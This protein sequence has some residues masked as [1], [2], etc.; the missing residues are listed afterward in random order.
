M[1]VSK[2][3]TAALAASFITSASIAQ[4]VT[5]EV[6]Y[7]YSSL[8]DVTFKR[9]LPLFNAA[10]PDITVK[11][12]ATYDNYEDATNT[13]LRES[14]ADKL[15]DVSFQGLNRQAGLVDKGIAK[16]LDPYIAKEANFSKEGYHQAMLDLG[17]FKG[18][19]YGLPF[20]VSL[21]VGFYN[22]DLLGKAGITTLPTTWDE[23]IRDCGKLRES[24][25][26]NPLFWGWNITG[27]W[28]FQALMWSQGEPI[29]K[30]GKVNFDGQAGLNALNTMKKLFRECKMLNL[31]V[32]DAGRP[33]VAGEV[34]MHFW[35]TSA[36]GA[37]ERAKGDFVLKTNEYPGMG[38][39]PKGL[40]A[41]G[42]SA[43]LVSGS[44]DPA[45]LDAAWQ[46][47]KFATSGKG[48]A[49]VAETTGYMP[50]NKAA[51]EMLGDFYSANPNKHTAVRQAG[52]LRE[53]I[54]YPGNNSLAIT[55]VI[56]DA[57][58]S[59]VTGESDD[60]EALQEELV[61]EVNSML[62]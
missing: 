54:A 11:F 59:I 47:L 30:N 13:V 27:N 56:Y 26:R 9:M 22:M 46:F 44:K 61:D 2:F 5:I 15:P 29:I 37:I 33:F 50:P 38:S 10:H 41:G 25:V 28:F 7:P 53:W 3:I 62:P 40:P 16:S 14:V 6:G 24:G 17:T 48:A 21:P 55:Q 18:G 52:L 23:V 45:V 51:N 12:R 35:S 60:M 8:F 57:I 34:A 20:S 31:P 49:I 42:N 43:M 32:G 36:V 58:E 39:A 1:K 19:V 4:A